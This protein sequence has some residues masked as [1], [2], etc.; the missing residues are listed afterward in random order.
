M[1]TSAFI[2]L[3]IIGKL[4]SAAHVK[5]QAANLSPRCFARR[6]DPCNRTRS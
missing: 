3:I 5:F 4:L 2:D 1:Q 6:I